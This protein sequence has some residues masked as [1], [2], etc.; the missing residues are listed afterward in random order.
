MS[1]RGGKKYNKIR[2]EVD[3]FLYDKDRKEVES[4]LY[5][6]NK[7]KNKKFN[8]EK[9]NMKIRKGDV[10]FLIIYLIILFLLL[11]LTPVSSMSFGSIGF[12]VNEFIWG[13][14][15]WILLYT[16]SAP[17]IYILIKRRYQRKK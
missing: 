1:K 3:S 6:T 17:I 12:F 7:K 4:F 15:L 16:I 11:L 5:E 8:Q 2:K 14:F 9:K 13:N 10:V